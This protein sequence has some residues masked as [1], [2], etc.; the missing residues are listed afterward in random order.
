MYVYRSWMCDGR[1]TT[2]VA[3]A[4]GWRWTTS[5]CNVDGFLAANQQK[6]YKMHKT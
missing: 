2:M 5:N 4:D 1:S 3:M 6:M